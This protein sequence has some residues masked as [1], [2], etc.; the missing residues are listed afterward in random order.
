M[1]TVADNYEHTMILAPDCAYC[2][3]VRRKLDDLDTCPIYKFDRL[4]LDC[5]PEACEYYTE[6]WDGDYQSAEDE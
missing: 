4:G 2:L 1:Y 5:V 3:A 6:D